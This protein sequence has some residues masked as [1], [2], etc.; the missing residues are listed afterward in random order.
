M[1]NTMFNYE[2]IWLDVNK[3]FRSKVRVCTKETML[4]RPWTYDG[5]STG[6]AITEKSEILLFPKKIIENPFANYPD[7]LLV[8]C[9]TSYE[10]DTRNLSEEIFNKLESEKPMFG[11]EQEFFVL[12][13]DTHEVIGWDQRTK[14][15]NQQFDYYCGIG[16]NNVS[17]KRQFMDDVLTNCLK[18]KLNIN[19]YNYEVAV[20]QAEFQ[21]TGI[22]IDACDQLLLLRYILER[23]GEKYDYIISYNC[24]HL[25]SEWNGS[26]LH[27]NFSTEH[28]R[29]K[30][31]DTSYAYQLIEK[32][33]DN[34]QETMKSYGQNNHLRLTGIHETSSYDKFSFG[35]GNRGA[36]VR[37]PLPA[38][39]DGYLD[40]LII[41]YFE[42]RRP[43][44]DADPYLVCKAMLSA[45]FL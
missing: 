18:A 42:D 15:H 30:P 41:P 34:H 4:S 36:S 5:S 25:G 8:L 43:A 14:H 35:V 40:E 26:G 21:V 2:Y 11:F 12:D 39:K 45:M 17:I 16:A 7:C 22:G 37:I 33:K 31:K 3:K 6:Q 13:K 44:S 32:L 38:N 9:A 19:G 28:M 24:K 29:E 20:G 10:E 27:T 23:T 1:S